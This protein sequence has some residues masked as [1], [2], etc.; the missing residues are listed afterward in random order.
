MAITDG[1]GGNVLRFPIKRTRAGGI[2][3]PPREIYFPLLYRVVQTVTQS[4]IDAVGLTKFEPINDYVHYTISEDTEYFG[5]ITREVVRGIWPGDRD[6]IVIRH[7]R[8][9]NQASA[10]LVGALDASG[11]KASDSI[12]QTEAGIFT[13]I[14][15][16]TAP[17]WPSPMVIY[18]AD[19]PAD[20]AIGSAT[21]EVA[22]TPDGVTT[23]SE[24]L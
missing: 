4:Q 13:M 12:Y 16:P 24:Y 6:S 15:R 14:R 7:H 23:R 18:V 22:T 19:Y 1:D 20:N 11:D 17:H 21:W 8:N 2:Y 3:C 10:Y 5:T 9:Y